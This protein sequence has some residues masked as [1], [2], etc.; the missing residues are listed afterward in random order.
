[1]SDEEK[2]ILE[3]VAKFED[4]RAKAAAID[5]QKRDLAGKRLIIDSVKVD[6]ELNALLKSQKDLEIAKGTNFGALTDEQVAKLQLDNNEYIEA[7]KKC[8]NFINES[9]NGLVPFFR[10]NLILIGGKTGEGKSTAVANI[11]YSTIKQRDKETGRRLR[12][13]MI[14]NEEAAPDVYN[15]VTALGKGWAYTNHNKFNSEQMK[16]F[17]NGIEALSRGGTLT[18]IDDRHNGTEGLT[19]SI[20]GICSIFDKLMA[21]KEFYDVIII[22]YYQNIKSSKLN[23]KLNEYE[24]QRQFCSALDGYKNNYPAPI[25]LFAQVA[26]PDKQGTPFEIRIKGTK[27]IID[28]STHAM[29]LVADRATYTTVFTV[30]KSRFTQAVGESLAVGFLKGLFVPYDEKFRAAIAPVI[31]KRLRDQMDR[32]GGLKVAGEPGNEYEVEK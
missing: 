29:E 31:E 1:M 27:L 21:D 28:K 20:E 26:P 17:S 16:A 2:Q 4:G 8:M 25:V 32:D 10:K 14:T 9:F 23:P 12:V 6:N 30:L 11:I 5:Q 15:R 24:V 18:V 7:A 13:L 3:D 22:D 19:T